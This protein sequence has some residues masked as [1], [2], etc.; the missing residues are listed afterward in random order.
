[1]KWRAATVVLCDKNVY[2]KFKG[3]FY[4]VSI[5]PTMLYGSECWK[6]KANKVKVAKLR[7]LRWTCG[8]TMFDMISNRVYRAELEVKTIINKMREGRLR[9]SGHVRRRPQST[10]VRRVEALRNKRD[11]S[12]LRKQ[13][14]GTTEQLIEDLES[15]YGFDFDL[16]I[17]HPICF[18][19][20]YIMVENFEGIQ[21]EC[22]TGESEPLFYNYLRPLISLDEGLYALACEEDVR[23]LATFV[24]SFKLIEI[25]IEH[26][27][28]ALD[29]Y[30]RPP[31][32]RATIEAI[33]D[34]PGSIAANKTEKM[35][36]MSD[37]MLTP[38]TDGSV[39]TYTQL[40]GVQL[41][42][43][44][45][46]L[47]GEAG[48]ADVAR[49]GVE[50]SRLSHDE[51]FR[52][53]DWKRIFKKRTKRKQKTNKT[54][55]E[56]EK[57]KS[58][59]EFIVEDV[60]LKDY[61]S[62]GEDVEHCN[63][64]ED[65][66]A[67]SD[68]QFFYDDRGIYTAYETKY[69]VQ[70]SEDAG[71]YDDDE[72]FLVDEANEIV[73][74]D[75]DVHLRKMDVI[76]PDGF[77]SDPGND[78]E[79]NDYRRRR[80]AKLSKEMEGVINASSQ[81]KYSFYTGKKYTTPKEAKDIVYLYSIKSRRNL[82]LYKNDNVR[83]RIFDQVR[84]NLDIPIK[85]VQDQL[86]RELEVQISMSKAFSAKA[87][88]EREIRG[89]HI[90]QYSMLKDY[91]V[92]LQTTNHNTT[93]KIAVEWN[94]DPSLPTRVF[95]RI[96]VCLGA[97][98][99]G[100]KACKR[101]LLGLD[102]AFMNGSFPGR[103][104]HPNSNFTFIS[105]RQKGIVPTIKTVFPYAEHIYCLRHIHEN[106]K[107]GWCGQAYRDMLWRAA[108][109]TNVKEFEKCRAKFDFLLNNICE[110]FNGKIVGSRNK[111]MITLLEYI[112]EYCMKIIVNVQSVIE[113]C[114]GPLTPTATRI[115]ESIKKE[116]H[117]MKDQVLGEVHMSNNTFATQASC[118]G[119]NNAE[120]NGS[121]SRQAQQ[122]EPV[123]GQDGLGGSGAGAV[124][125]L[126]AAGQGGPGGAGV[127]R[128]GSSYTRWTKRRVQTER[129][130]PQKRTP[131]QPESQPST[132]SQVPVSETRNADRR[133]MCDGIPTQS[134][135]AG[136]ASEWSFL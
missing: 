36:C 109:P 52:V 44:E 132:S 136:G 53:D 64:Q 111:L 39:I 35:L 121:A 73:K 90:L 75:V 131:T 54:E 60:A 23:C 42:F 110:V 29:C 3:K 66:S 40:S 79:T 127:G 134:S 37:C 135:A 100:F 31:R 105:D 46:K 11:G 8:K 81:W 130:S 97:L 50:S 124:I 28:T 71:T 61:V 58:A 101:E 99:L 32:F 45:T 26:G 94:T 93:V 91:V 112:R 16:Q 22:Y 82:E 118:L 125:G 107:Q 85:A 80:L 106:I 108:S 4:R 1:M 70:S 24:R 103:N 14:T 63:G 76:N 133:E 119:G 12:S 87:K 56:M 74:P 83:I 72:D 128:Q 89:D 122:T 68:G 120:A 116:A 38:P 96:Y 95:Q 51:S 57:T 115:M 6:E 86:Q 9:W 98:K 117:L 41:S 123:V 21:A 10:L 5:R 30:I 62:S 7:M 25:Y 17:M 78:D 15:A 65:E 113:K 114:N 59:K 43:E 20:E 27:V 102:D 92:E 48:F 13:W 69:D 129:I 49:S 67:P 47:D 88:A 19:F 84:V 34:E 126:S 18:R 77:D 2:L 55:H 104:L 33:S